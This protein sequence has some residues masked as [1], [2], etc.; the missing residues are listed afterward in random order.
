MPILICTG[1][2]ISSQAEFHHDISAIKQTAVRTA[3]IPEEMMIL[4]NIQ[5]RRM[6]LLWISQLSNKLQT[7]SPFTIQCQN[8][9]V[10]FYIAILM[11]VINS[12]DQWQQIFLQVGKRSAY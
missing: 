7:Q 12:T 9:F 10:H 6:K 8:L 4:R 5:R 11:T 3:T 2:S 1:V